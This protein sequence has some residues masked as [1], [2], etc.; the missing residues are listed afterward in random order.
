MNEAGAPARPSP[1]D[2]GAVGRSFAP[3]FAEVTGDGIRRFARAIGEYGAVC[4]ERDTAIAAG[5][6]DV[7]APPTYIFVVQFGAMHP[8]DVLGEL[9]IE[10]DAGKL[11]HAEQAFD[12]VRPI[13]AG[14]RLRFEEHIADITEKKGGALLF[15]TIETIVTDATGERVATIRHTEVVRM[16]L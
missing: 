13:H 15:V 14:D 7:V 16:T 1:Y 8:A 3:A 2:R 4:H 10:G 6:P 12:Y 5:F 9:G 11:L